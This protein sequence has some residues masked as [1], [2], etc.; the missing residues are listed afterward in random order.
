M[1]K[2]VFPVIYFEHVHQ[3]L[4]K[5]KSCILKLIS[6]ENMFYDISILKK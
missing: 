5:R 4:Y 3:P 1:K 2:S 6:P